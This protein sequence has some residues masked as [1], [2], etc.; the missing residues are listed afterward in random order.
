M[1]TSVVSCR[2][3]LRIAV[4]LTLCVLLLLVQNVSIVVNPASAQGQRQSS[5]RE[6]GRDPANRK[7]ICRISKALRANQARSVSRRLRFHPRFVHPKCRMS[8]GTVDASVIRGHAA[9]WAR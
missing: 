7:A 8:R 6:D 5:N 9:S 4:A 1:H 2:S 3:A